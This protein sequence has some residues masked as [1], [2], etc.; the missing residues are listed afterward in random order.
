MKQLISSLL[1]V[2]F[3]NTITGKYFP[4]ANCTLFYEKAQHL[5]FAFRSRINYE[6]VVQSKLSMY[7]HPNDLIF[8]IGG[9]IGQYALVFSHLAT[10]TGRVIS[11]EPDSKNFSFL[12]FNATINGLS[13]IT[14]LKKGV[15]LSK[16]VMNFFR[17]S[18][19]GGRQSSFKK[20]YVGDGYKGDEELVEITTI[21]E[22][23]HQYGKPA[24]VKI[25]VEGFETD[26]LAGLTADLPDTIFLV[27]VRDTTKCF[28]FEYFDSRDFACYNAD[29]QTE[30][31]LPTA[32][33]VPGFCNL[34]FK[35]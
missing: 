8:D 35:K 30:T 21:D 22:L 3:G 17:D 1:R 26:V 28:V 11:V 6:L 27:E 15:G 4:I 33:L 20:E 29:T 18:E 31:L 34:I 5:L 2:F 16:A 12:Q 7:I 24:F 19:T 32:D 13:N 9:N 10:P 14:C 25:D 23:I